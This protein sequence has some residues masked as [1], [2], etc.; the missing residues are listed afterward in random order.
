MQAF[1]YGDRRQQVT[2]VNSCTVNAMNAESNAVNATLL[3]PTCQR[4]LSLVKTHGPFG[5]EHAASN[6]TCK[7]HRATATK[8]DCRPPHQC[9]K[10]DKVVQ[11]GYMQHGNVV[12]LVAYSVES[13]GQ[14]HK[15]NKITSE[16][17]H[18]A[19]CRHSKARMSQ[20]EPTRVCK[21]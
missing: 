3:S 15:Y 2:H 7:L 5:S 13:N 12:S 4:F 9:R 8:N 18:L 17:P 19:R 14:I 10:R 21:A 20:T 11:L 6:F 16:I 1:R